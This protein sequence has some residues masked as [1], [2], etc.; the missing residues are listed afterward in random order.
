MLT[1]TCL[2]LILTVRPVPF[3]LAYW[4]NSF[5]N[6]QVIYGGKAKYTLSDYDL[7]AI[8][9]YKYWHGDSPTKLH[10]EVPPLG[11]LIIGASITFFSDQTLFNF[12]SGLSCLCLLYFIASFL[13]IN[14]VFRSVFM[15]LLVTD[16]LFIESMTT[17]NLDIF[18]LNFVL[19]AFYT[20]LHRKFAFTWLFVGLLMTVKI[21]VP[22]L[23]LSGL[24]IGHTLYVYGFSGFIN[25]IKFLP[26]MIVGYLLPYSSAILS[27]SAFEFI[28]FQRWLISWWAGSSKTPPGGIL[29][30]IY[31]G[32]WQTWWGKKEII[33][34]VSWSPLWPISIV[35]GLSSLFRIISLKSNWSLIWGWLAAYLTFLFLISPFPRYL[36]LVIPFSYLLTTK[37]VQ[38]LI[39]TRK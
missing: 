7:Y 6:S 4:E 15:L 13:E 1:L 22:G 21:F 20:Y 35:G 23:I 39:T 33:F 16:K 2:L 12:L 18:Q 31:N 24:M 38:N 37:L 9:G 25:L 5:Q 32:S 3:M 27:Q 36:V 26:A 30:I 19:L 8:V 34:V 29:S 10:P 11:K 17:S 14:L 28:K